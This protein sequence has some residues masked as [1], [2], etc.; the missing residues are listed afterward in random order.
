[1]KLIRCNN[2]SLRKIIVKMANCFF[3][4]KIIKLNIK[5]Q[6]KDN[7]NTAK[8]YFKINHSIFNGKNTQIIIFF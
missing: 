4:L 1:M 2:E 6:S 5:S 3:F 8:L 7:I